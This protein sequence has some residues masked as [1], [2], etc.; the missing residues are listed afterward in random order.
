MQDP[1]KIIGRLGVYIAAADQ[2]HQKVKQH[3]HSTARE[4][5][6]QGIFGFPSDEAAAFEALPTEIRAKVLHLEPSVVRILSVV[7]D[8]LVPQFQQTWNFRR[9][10]DL[11]RQAIASVRTLT[12]VDGWL[13]PA[14]P[15]ADPWALHPVVSEHATVYWNS[16]QYRVAVD[17][18]ARALN[19]HLQTKLGRPDLDNTDL[20]RQ[21]FS[22]RLPSVDQP[23]LRFPELD[24]KVEER[25]WKSRHRVRWS[26]PPD[27][28]RLC[29]T[30]QLTPIQTV[31]DPRVS[32]RPTVL[33][34]LVCWQGGSTK[35]SA[36]RMVNK[37]I[38]VG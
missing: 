36:A 23:R 38:Y 6:R 17:E 29:A 3:Q 33:V 16:G 12:E 13:G 26:L 9:R 7:D 28:F 27:S 2:V 31:M 32:M 35:Q 37:I 19:V 11:V 8:G 4:N 21:T 14:A 5:A 18:A 15:A 24:K 34:R 1:E 22:I 30:S 20:A 10:A 25:T